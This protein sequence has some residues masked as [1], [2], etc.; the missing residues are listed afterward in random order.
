[1]EKWQEGGGVWRRCEGI[2]GGGSL[3][4]RWLVEKKR[5]H[6]Y[7]EAKRQEYRSRAVFKLNQINERFIVI[8]RGNVVVDLGCSPGGWCEVLRETVGD[9]GLV[10]GLDIAR[11]RPLEK[12]TFIHGDIRDATTR[13]ALVDALGGRS[14]DV[15]V[16]DMSPN[17]SGN[18]SI[19]HARS[20]ELARMAFG[21]AKENLRRGG[22]FVVKV[23]QGE[24][25]KSLLDEFKKMF[26]SC[27]AHSPEA[28]RAR[29]SEIYIVGKGFLGK[30]KKGEEEND[31]MSG[32]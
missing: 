13:R 8:K 23:F 11:M 2:A 3:S 7:R 4:K 19:D 24:D 16:S 27:R 22:G 10:I 6:Y 26:S 9:H 21:F 25:F 5:E 12:V 14:V 31:V 15:V 28:S 30:D 29:S 32:P 17:L 18:Y 1:M 20:I